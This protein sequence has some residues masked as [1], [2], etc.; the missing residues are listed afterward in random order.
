MPRPRKPIS[1]DPLVES[2]RAASRA[3]YHRNKD[4]ERNRLFL[5]RYG[6]TLEEF[7]RMAEEQGGLCAICHG[8]P[9]GHGGLHV[10]HDHRL[11]KVRSL[12]CFS[13]NAAIG[14]LHENAELLRAAAD[15]LESWAEVTSH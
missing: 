9:N 1:D 4:R 3:W 8:P 12:L 11:N 5:T 6:I 7:N 2:N 10:D 14:M 15:Y 13:C